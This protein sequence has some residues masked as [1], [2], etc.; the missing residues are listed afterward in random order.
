MKNNELAFQIPLG[1]L[2]TGQTAQL[3]IVVPAADFLDIEDEN[4]AF[5]GD[6][7]VSGEAYLAEEE[8]VLHIG[9]S[10][11]SLVKCLICDRY[12]ETPIE[13]KNLY[14]AVSLKEI[15]GAFFDMKDL[16]RENLLLEAPEFAECNGGQCPDREEIKNYMHDP[17]KG[18]NEGFSP[19]SDLN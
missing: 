8:L 14:H 19:F 13:M 4:L 1:P 5:S 11:V 15:K 2:Q 6:V 17:E 3:D 12:I 9:I 10:A 18:E 16:V 7:A